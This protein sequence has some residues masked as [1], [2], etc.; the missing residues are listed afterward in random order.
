LPGCAL[1]KRIP[2]AG[3]E[4]APARSPQAGNN[5]WT[6]AQPPGVPG[7]C[8][9]RRA[10]PIPREWLTMEGTLGSANRAPLRGGSLEAALPEGPAKVGSP[11]ADLAQA[12]SPGGLVDGARFVHLTGRL[13]QPFL[14]RAYDKRC[15]GHTGRG[16]QPRCEQSQ[17]GVLEPAKAA[18][19]PLS[20]GSP[21]GRVPK[22][23]YH[24][25]GA[26]R[27][28]P[29]GGSEWGSEDPGRARES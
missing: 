13:L 10:G 9:V 25:E 20:Q 29:R 19:E 2:I 21:A 1:S 24:P 18:F 5:L 15:P 3:V 8:P 23:A 11:G 7:S 4:K 16:N 27:G 26:A 28:Q 17:R 22:G 6:T 14:S 12:A